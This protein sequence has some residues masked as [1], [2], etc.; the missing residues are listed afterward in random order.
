MRLQEKSQ[1]EYMWT[2]RYTDSTERHCILFM[3][4]SM[5]RPVH[6]SQEIQYKN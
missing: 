2:M 6:H 5:P 3:L 4:K 1:S